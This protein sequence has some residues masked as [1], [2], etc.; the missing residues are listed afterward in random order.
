ASTCAGR[1]S[2]TTSVRA[3]RRVPASSTRDEVPSTP[4]TRSSADQRSH[5]YDDA[6]ALLERDGALRGASDYLAAAIEGNGRLV[7][8]A[9]EA[10]V[11]KTSLVDR[12]V[13]EAPASVHVA[14]GAC[15]GSATPPP[16]G[17][18]LEMLPDLPPDVWPAGVERHEVFT[19]LSTALGETDTP[20]LLVLE[21]AHWADE[22]TLDLVRHLARR[23]HR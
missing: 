14:R 4:A 11:G 5:P 18:L 17:P 19:R 1:P 12:V 22:A 15:D 9:G 3:S 6:M 2:R 23:V 20:Y 10:G 7:F 13:S 21:D 8:V 16:L